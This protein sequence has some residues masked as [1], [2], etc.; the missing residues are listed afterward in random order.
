M[1][2]YFI[3]SNVLTPKIKSTINSLV[4]ILFPWVPFYDNSI[5]TFTTVIYFP[6]SQCLNLSGI[7]Q[8]KQFY[9][10]I[11]ERMEIVI[12]L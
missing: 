2:M 1:C 10:I 7:R 3:T 11:M 5:N 12:G 8:K 9:I 4:D 6:F